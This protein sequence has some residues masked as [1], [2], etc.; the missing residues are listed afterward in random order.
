MK[1]LFVLVMGFLAFVVLCIPDPFEAIPL[2][3]ALDEAT[4]TAVLL[5]CARYFGFDLSRF[6]GKKN[7]GGNHDIVDVEA[8]KVRR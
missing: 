1:S 6:F 3:G 8:G 7:R 2:F 4:A 5:A